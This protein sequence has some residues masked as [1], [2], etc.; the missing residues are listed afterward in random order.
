M[1]MTGS[2][3]TG[4][5][6]HVL[7]DFDGVLCDSRDAAAE[8]LNAL[9][10]ALSIP[11]PHVY[12]QEEFATVF[13]GPL[14]TS[15]RRFGVTDEDSAR[16]FSAHSA[17]MRRRAG[18]LLPFDGAV[19]GIAERIP[20]QCSIV[21]SAYSEAIANVLE[22]SG[23]TPDAVFAHISGRQEGVSKGKRIA[24][25]MA[26][27]GVEKSHVVYVGDLVSDI[28]YAR[29]LGIRCIAV[30]YGYHPANYLAVFAPFKLVHSPEQLADTLDKLA[31][32][33]K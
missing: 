24:S 17:A 19:R 7:L 18:S 8:E 6:A 11:L 16:F 23:V 30:G 26:L 33:G 14:R 13:P 20:K 4:K 31:L 1:V 12:G 15:L 32:A 25:T 5:H 10:R 27:L 3:T 21:S 28:L 29:S 22:R 2:D 9:S